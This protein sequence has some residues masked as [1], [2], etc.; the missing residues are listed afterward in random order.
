M[1]F[2]SGRLLARNTL[3]NLIGL[4]LPLV[5]AVVTIPFIIQGLGIERFG[6]LS[7]AWVV[8]GYFAI[9]DLGLGRAT[10]KFVA[11]ALGKGEE[12]QVPRVVW[13]AVTIQV[14]F[15]LLGAIVLASITPLLVER[16]LNIPPALIKEAKDTFYL[17]SLSIPVILVSSS[18]RGVLEAAQR[19]DLVNI[20][21]VPSSTLTF[22][23]PLVG[24]FL[25]FNLPG[26]VALI[27]VVRLAELAVYVVMSIRF[28]P[29]LKRYSGS[30][31]LFPRL[32]SFGG[33][34]TVTSIVG[35]VLVYLDHF[36]IGSLLSIA[37]VAFYAAPYR[38]VMQ[39]WIVSGSLSMA[40][41]PAFSALGA[42]R[43]EILQKLYIRSI[44]YLL[45]TTGPLVLILVVFAGS[46]LQLW[47]GPDFAQQSTL[48]LQIL[49]LGALIGLLAPIS[50]ALIQGLGRP[51]ILSKLYLLYLP[52]NIGLVWFLVQTMGIAGAALSF[53]LR[54]LIE[55]VL[56]IIISSKLIHLPLSYLIKSLWQSVGI[57]LALG[58]LL[59]WGASGINL[60][61]VQGSF[62]IVVILLFV[63]FTW[64]YM[65]D[66]TDKK[67]IASVAPRLLSFKRGQ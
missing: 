49:L 4:G 26:I 30:F 62:V 64:R 11:E 60:F 54:A 66:E 27:L 51:D 34:V 52:L 35:P 37:A 2:I 3:F 43:K 31:A 42:T 23:L 46:I 45:L 65:L 32:F 63:I 5:V 48:V 61:A 38:I 41:F 28:A 1:N 53:A 44:K 8:L 19:F 29:R 40:L 67:V 55:T 21:R 18:F 7:L 39:L 14:L 20:V 57:L 6:L 10:T 15:G 16:I 33:W 17:L 12:E 58:V 56:L 9:F 47:L 22:L 25:G 24:L 50:G 36:L 13:T 59:W